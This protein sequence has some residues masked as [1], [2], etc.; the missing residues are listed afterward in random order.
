MF[1]L[2]RPWWISVCTC[3][4]VWVWVWVGGRGAVLPF[5]QHI[6]G[7]GFGDSG[8]LDDSEI[9]RVGGCWNPEIGRFAEIRRVWLELA[10]HEP[11]RLGPKSVI[12]VRGWLREVFH[13]SGPWVQWGNQRRRVKRKRKGHR[14]RG[15][16]K[17]KRVTRYFILHCREEGG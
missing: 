13:S 6:S 8:N 17:V 4:W 7:R 15:K 16:R 2:N 1:I 11:Y 9:R 14:K 12:E 3:V 5:P 10:A